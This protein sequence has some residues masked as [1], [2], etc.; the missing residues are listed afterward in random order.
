MTLEGARMHTGDTWQ[1]PATGETMHVVG[2]YWKREARDE[3][4]ARLRSR[5]AG[6]VESTEHPNPVDSDSEIFGTYYCLSV[7]DAESSAGMNALY[8]M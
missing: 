5:F 7:P 2:A 3:G 1:D 6:R 4:E 8:G